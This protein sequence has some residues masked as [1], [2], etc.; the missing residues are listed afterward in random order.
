MSKQSNETRT[1]QVGGNSSGED[2]EVSARSYDQNAVQDRMAKLRD[3]QKAQKEKER[4]KDNEI[5][6]VPVNDE[7]VAAL[8]SATTWTS[9]VATRRLKE[10]HGDFNAVMKD[11]LHGKFLAV[12]A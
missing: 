1:M 6:Q 11:I 4:A 12:K 9:A 7:D 2:K 8:V 10:K 5:A 3:K